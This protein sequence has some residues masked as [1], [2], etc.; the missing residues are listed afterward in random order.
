M[1]NAGSLRFILKPLSI[2]MVRRF[3][4]SKCRSPATIRTSRGLSARYSVVQAFSGSLIPPVLAWQRDV[5]V[6][7]IVRAGT[8]YGSLDIGRD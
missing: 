4:S 5:F 2:R 3:L 6:N 1:L 7:Q 8:L